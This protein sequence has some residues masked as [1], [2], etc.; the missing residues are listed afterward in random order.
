LPQPE[1]EV[2]AHQEQGAGE[3]HRHADEECVG[4]PLSEEEPPSEGD[5]DRGEVHQERGVGN[6]GE[7]DRP[8]PEC[9]IPR[10]EHP[11]QHQPQEGATTRRTARRRCS[12]AVGKLHP[13]PQ[14][15]QGESE[16]PE[17]RGGWPQLAQADEDG[18]AGYPHRTGD[19]GRQR[20]SGAGDPGTPPGTPDGVLVGVRAWLS[21]D[22][23][24]SG[25]A[26]GVPRAS[27]SPVP[28]R[29]DPAQR[30]ESRLLGNDAA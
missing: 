5:E 24:S 14:P 23:F 12:P 19:Q 6:G 15:R 26:R 22:R 7:L 25:F 8:V 16:A 17:G 11:G 20:E 21:A 27:Y 30:Y 18:R 3:R 1:A 9:Q 10:E 29:R 4:E 13:Q 28:E 2:S